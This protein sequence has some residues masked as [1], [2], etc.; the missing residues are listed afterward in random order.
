MKIQDILAFAT[1]GIVGGSITEKKR[2]EKKKVNIDRCP[3][4]GSYRIQ[5]KKGGKFRCLDCGKVSYCVRE[6][7]VEVKE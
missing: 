3:K 2:K 1:L 6:I 4:C 7:W 5:S